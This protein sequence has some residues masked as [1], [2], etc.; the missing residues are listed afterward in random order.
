MAQPVFYQTLNMIG[1]DPTLYY[2]NLATAGGSVTPEYPAPPFVPG[3]LA[4]GS[5]GSQF[6]FVQASSAINL[7][8]F[9]AINT[10]QAVAPYQANSVNTTN[11]FGSLLM[12]IG[13]SGLVVKQSVTTI[14]AG[15]MFWA[16]TKGQF[17]P[18]TTS[19]TVMAATVTA[20]V[21]PV[22]LYVALTGVGTGILT[23]VSTT[24]SPG[25]AGIVCINSLTVS[26]AGSIV[27]P[28]GTLSNG[29]TIGPVVAMNNPRLIIV[30]TS[31]SPVSA[32]AAT[33]T[34]SGFAF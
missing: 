1:V 4:F 23:S 6:I 18:A 13:S 7:T 10:G 22:A 33:N 25:I 20:G 5:D 24:L 2:T 34:G 16:C 11:I 31:T 9:V 29:F 8:D 12:G 30:G 3:T 15:A 17:V 28:V 19:G 32:N 21:G 14:P 26:I 27:P